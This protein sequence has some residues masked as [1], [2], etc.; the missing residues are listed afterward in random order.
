MCFV[1][2]FASFFSFVV[3]IMLFF[4]SMLFVL[5]PSIDDEMN[6]ICLYINS[7]CHNAPDTTERYC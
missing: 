4:K 1:S 2:F 5:L 3:S 6:F 7:P